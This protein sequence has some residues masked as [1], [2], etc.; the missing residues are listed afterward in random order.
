MTFEIAVLA[1]AFLLMAVVL[2]SVALAGWLRLLPR[3]RWAGIR[4]DSVRTSDAAWA[5]GHRAAAPGLALA[6]IAPLILG[7]ALLVERPAAAGDWLIT[8]IGVGLISG[9]LMALS[10]R[11][12]DE[13]ARSI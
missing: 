4:T 2:L 10:V 1:F 7:F 9:G 12:A 13:A 6:A 11:R 8:I 5:A 3:N